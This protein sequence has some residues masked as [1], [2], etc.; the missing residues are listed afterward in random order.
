MVKVRALHSLADVG[1][2]DLSAWIDSLSGKVDL[3]E[4]DRQVLLQAC[5]FSRQMEEQA[6]AED[7]IWAPGTSSLRTGLEM[8]DIL[9][10]LHMDASGLIA[11]VLYRAVRER[12][13]TLQDVRAKFGKSIASLIDSVQQMAVI[14]TLRNDS[15]QGVFG[16]GVGQQAAKVREMLVSVID[17]VR[18][19]LIKIAERT[20]AIRAV[21]DAPQPKRIRV[22]RE[23]FD[24]Y[25]PL[26]HRLGIGQLKW[27]L[28]DL[29]FRY[30]EP[31]EYKRIAKLLDEKRIDRQ[32]FIDE[33]L[34]ILN[35]ELK[36][37]DIKG[38]IY[39]RA[40]HIYSIWRKM[41]RK[42]I[43]FSQVYDIRAVRIL[44]PE[45]AE[46]Y[47]VLGI[48]HTLWRHIPNEFDDYIAAPKENGYR[49]L[50]TAVIGPRNKVLEV[51]IR[52][53]QMDEEAELGVCSHWRYKGSDAKLSADSYE[54]KILWLRQVLEWHEEIEGEQHVQELLNRDNS[55]DR[56]YVFTPE[57]HVVD[58]PQGSTPLDFAYRVHTQIGHRC[59][60]AKIN[61]RIAPL[62]T[63]LHTSDQVEIITGKTEAPSRDWLLSSLGY[64]H[65]SRARAKVQQWFRK[66]DREK[67][68]VAGRTIVTREL[69]QLG[70]R[71]L[72]LEVIAEK[73]NKR[74]EDGLY[75][76]IGAGDVTVPQ[77][78]KAAQSQIDSRREPGF[79]VAKRAQTASRYEKS[80]VY[81]YGV[82]NLMSQIA[83]CCNPVPGDSISGYITHGRG[84]SI[85]RQDCGNLLRMQNEE[86][87]RVIQVSW[88]GAPKRVYPVKIKLLAYD[89]PGLIRDISAVLD[90]LGVNIVEM[91]IRQDEYNNDNACM[92]L[93]KLEVMGI[94]ELSNVMGRLRQVTNLIDIERMSD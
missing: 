32:N 36:K 19:A 43:G 16:H 48:I 49:S 92:M 73:F 7:N 10:E 79:K 12:K 74:G 67:N 11:A 71:E 59:R 38:E 22:A 1:D 85:H 70:V 45:V 68:I 44:V 94:E 76:A 29:A 27:E 78:L 81:I 80:D 91:T 26:A 53:Y 28:E 47:A 72:D 50:H 18:V 86:P 31:Q 93:M 41:Q 61:G 56:I 17:D 64:L 25:A 30:L 52:T 84:V 23:V 33:V 65:T 54:E 15:E 57:G 37:A 21:K 51:Q 39:G 55:P 82:G 6:I 40:K 90:N 2:I 4:K 77:F 5:E 66:Q 62:G 13:V 34:Q 83:H 69:R 14:S 8:A 35:A 63:V 60:G 24:V 75:A 87:E 3:S 9:A 58:L 46:C 42:N 89:R 88:G 20:C